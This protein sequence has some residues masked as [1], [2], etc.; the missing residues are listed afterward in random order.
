[1]SLGGDSIIVSQKKH[2]SSSS[3][4]RQ[5]LCAAGR[6]IGCQCSGSSACRSILFAV[7]W[8][9]VVEAVAS[10]SM[11]VT[12]MSNVEELVCGNGPATADAV[13][14]IATLEPSR[15]HAPNYPRVLEILW[16]SMRF[17]HA[18]IVPAIVSSRGLGSR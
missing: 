1:M 12:P 14:L 15:H 9:E 16:R 8:A 13:D 11:R 3:P 7:L 2:L 18:L 6:L 17:G 10:T 4:R 5:S